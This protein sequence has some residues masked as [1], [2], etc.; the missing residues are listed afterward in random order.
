MPLTEVISNELLQMSTIKYIYFWD[1]HTHTHKNCTHIFR[2]FTFSFHFGYYIHLISYLLSLK[3]EFNNSVFIAMKMVIKST[4]THTK[5]ERKRHIP[6]DCAY[7]FII[8]CN[9]FSI[10]S[11]N[12][13]DASY[14]Y[15]TAAQC[16]CFFCVLSLLN[17]NA[18]SSYSFCHFL[19]LLFSNY[20]RGTANI[21]HS[22]YS[23]TKYT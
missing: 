14:D 4:H 10:Y 1:K 2:L 6:F 19:L 21:M 17:N 16:V 23:L 7:N 11:F 20:G 12:L 15:A 9:S 22:N 18:F 3:N 8:C 13:R 5:Q